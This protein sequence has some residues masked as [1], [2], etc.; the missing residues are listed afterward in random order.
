MRTIFLLRAQTDTKLKIPFKCLPNQM[1]ETVRQQGLDY[2]VIFNINFNKNIKI[3]EFF[4]FLVDIINNFVQL[5]IFISSRRL[6]GA[7]ELR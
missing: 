3:P 2:S 5:R 1:V 6:P 7:A 4:L